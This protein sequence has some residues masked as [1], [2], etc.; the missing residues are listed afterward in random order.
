[1]AYSTDDVLGRVSFTSLVFTKCG[2]S[3]GDSLIYEVPSVLEHTEVDDP[4]PTSN[5][6]ESEGFPEGFE[7]EMG[8]FTKG[9][10]KPSV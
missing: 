8:N 3:R 10:G 4:P 1:M 6:A 5:N 2:L 7:G 9:R